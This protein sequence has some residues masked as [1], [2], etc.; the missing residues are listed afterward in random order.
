M[1]SLFRVTWLSFRWCLAAV[2]TIAGFGIQL[3]LPL[4]EFA[5]RISISLMALFIIAALLIKPMVVLQYGAMILGSLL[6]YALLAKGC[7]WLAGAIRPTPE[8]WG[9]D[10]EARAEILPERVALPRQE[11]PITLDLVD[12]EWK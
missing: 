6:F 3:L 1:G 7:L 8:E 11:Q 10:T 9:G 2:L 5:I 12:G 4:A